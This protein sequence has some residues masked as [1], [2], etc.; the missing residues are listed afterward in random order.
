MRWA[1]ACNSCTNV[2][3]MYAS[4]G[5]ATVNT[6]CCGLCGTMRNVTDTS[7]GIELEAAVED[8]LVKVAIL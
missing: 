8:E 4:M 7:S 3:G 6:A 5:T 2:G 1:I